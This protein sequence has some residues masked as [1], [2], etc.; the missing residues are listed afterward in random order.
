MTVYSCN[1]LPRTLQLA[2]SSGWQVLGAG[3]GADAVSSSE[4][5]MEGPSILV[6]GNEG[7]GLRT[8]VRRSC[9]RMIQIDS[10][11]GMAISE[12]ASLVMGVDSLNV[13]VA[14]GILLHGLLASSVKRQ[15]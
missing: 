1:N 4:F 15:L 14:T 2:A 3:T 6:V 13:S 8:N 9:N 5:V 12:D 7:Y 10:Q 11:P